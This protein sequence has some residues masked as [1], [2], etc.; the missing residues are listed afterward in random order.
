MLNR[1]LRSVLMLLA[2]LL[3][4]GCGGSDTAQVVPGNGAAN[5]APVPAPGA[6]D[7]VKF[8]SARSALARDL[9]PTVTNAELGAL[10]QG[11]TAFAFAL[12]QGLAGEPDDLAF[13]PHSISVALAMVYAGAKGETAAEMAQALGFHLGDAALHRAFNA[14]DL[15]LASR[16]A[17]AVGKDGKPFR[18]RTVNAAWAQRGYPFVSTYLDTLAQAYGA[19][20]NL[21][22]FVALPEPSRQAI[23]AWVAE[24]TEQRIPEL[25]AE[26]GVDAMTRLVLTNAVYFNAAWASPFKAE[27]TAP[28]P[29]RRLDGST[30]SVPTMMQTGNFRYAN[31]DSVTA[32]EMPYD[33]GEVSMLLLLGDG[34]FKAFES[35]LSPA[36]LAKLVAA[37]APTQ[38]EVHLPRFESRLKSALVPVLRQLG[39]RDAFTPGVADLSGIDGQRELYVSGVVHE[40]FVL[41]DEAGTEAAAATGV[42]VS[43][44]S[45]GPQPTLV[46]FDRPFVYLIRD[47]ATGAILFLGRVLDPAT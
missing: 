44:T 29:F 5:T 2:G 45:I 17:G 37:M 10:V 23:N 25:L 35:A 13:S 6:V 28:A 7:T 30:V 40:A 27:Q 31:I 18:L 39:I 32:L 47:V 21:L 36:L 8:D 24:Q 19:G 9:A 34:D 38:V 41:V 12:Y 4:A 3:L 14:L 22:D 1:R 33:G 11:N 43:V 42:T 26:G 20:L 46:R 15:A 16:G